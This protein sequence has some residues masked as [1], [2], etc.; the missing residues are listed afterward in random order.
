MAEQ[1]PF[2]VASFNQYLSEKKLMA[3]Y[4]A[5]SDTYYLPPRAI[6]P[7]THSDQ[8]E[9]A[10]LSGDATLAAFTV[11]SIAPTAMVAEGYGRDN[12]YVSGIVKTAEGPKISARI[13]GLDPQDPNA[14]RIGTP[15]KVDFVDVGEGESARTFL[16]FKVG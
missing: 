15:L 4:C 13:L 7:Q 11:V 2:T 9:W 10:E 14:I 12:P 16:A 5:E 3:S 6:C 8:M 1:R